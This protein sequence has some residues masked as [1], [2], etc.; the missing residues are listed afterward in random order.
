VVRQCEN[1]LQRMGCEIKNEV[2]CLQ[3]LS[4]LVP[5]YY[6]AVVS[7]PGRFEKIMVQ[8]EHSE[9]TDHTPRPLVNHMNCSDPDSKQDDCNCHRVKHDLNTKQVAEETT[10]S[11]ISP[12]F[13]SPL[14]DGSISYVPDDTYLLLQ[15]LTVGFRKPYIM[16]I[17][18]GSQ[19]Y[20][21]DASQ[22]KR[23]KELN[24]YKNQDTFGL[25]IVGMKT[26]HPN[27][28]NS[29]PGTGYVTY[30]KHYGRSLQTY[31]DL[32][33]A[34]RIFFSCNDTIR[35]TEQQ[36]HINNM[37]DNHVV[38]AGS[39]FQRDAICEPI[40]AGPT[41]TVTLSSVGPRKDDLTTTSLLRIQVISDLKGQLR[42]IR[43]WFEE[44]NHSFTFYASSLLVI[45][46]G[47]DDGTTTMSPPP[48]STPPVIK[49]IDFGR[50][51]RERGGD[52]GYIQ[53]LQLL[54]R[55]W[56]DLIEQST[57]V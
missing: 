17:K 45:Y 24:N 46:D 47:E 4:E 37:R 2:L 12:S 29:D 28:P 19:T 26:Y 41:T 10:T 52:T 35:T 30:D 50:V 8:Q 25:R 13:R 15:D 7:I 14:R 49:M 34:F 51:R 6:G 55:I 32:V 54:D 43:R 21:P 38:S 44:D 36:H 39:S 1:Q 9:S 22:E 53:G 16:D 33:S 18:M 23:M 20:E 42:P 57:I 31:D 48:S 11:H 3:K 5:S 40:A 27:H 56:N